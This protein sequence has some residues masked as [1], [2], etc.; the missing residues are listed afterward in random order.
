LQQFPDPWHQ[1]E[2]TIHPL[3][4]R[5]AL[6]AHLKA[7]PF[8]HFWIVVAC[9]SKNSSTVIL[10]DRL[11]G[12]LLEI[13]L[14]SRYLI[15]TDISKDFFPAPEQFLTA[16][17]AVAFFDKFFLTNCKIALLLE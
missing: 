13:L 3:P 1:Q 4:L 17:T 6:A 8:K 5:I 7:R 14:N 2:A 10:F 12:F 9:L 15:D 16:L 11:Q